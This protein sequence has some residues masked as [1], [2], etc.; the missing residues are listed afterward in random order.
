[1]SFIDKTHQ[2][3]GDNSNVLQ[4]T[5]DIN[6]SGN[7]AKEVIEICEY[8]ITQKMAAIKEEAKGIALKWASDFGI[9]IALRL[10][11]VLDEKLMAKLKTPDVQYAIQE[12]IIQVATKGPSA[13]AE[14]LQELII[15]KITNDDEERNLIIDHAI[16]V[17]KRTTNNELKLMALIYSIRNNANTINDINFHTILEN[18]DPFFEIKGFTKMFCWAL[19]HD[20]YT[21]PSKL[22]DMVIGNPDSL[23]SINVGMMKVKGLIDPEHPY[24]K[25]YFEIIEFKTNHALS[26]RQDLFEK[27]FPYF[28]KILKNFRIEKLEHLNFYNLTTLGEVMA[29]S[30]LIAKGFTEAKAK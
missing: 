8:V 29:H 14:L 10:D 23:Y 30:F 26:N 7:S 9:N 13:K 11:D 16:E 1:M 28:D 24:E 3:V 17:T 20:M 2:S 21:N 18:P 22:F 5:R 6:I 19:Y 4:A 27:E 25:N 15:S 12:A